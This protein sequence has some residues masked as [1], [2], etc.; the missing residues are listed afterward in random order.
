MSEK[1]TFYY[2]FNRLNFWL[3][4][5][6]VISYLLICC[7]IKYRYCC[8][9]TEYYILLALM[10]IS[11]GLW[12]YKH[13]IKQTLAII[14]DEYIKIDH[15]HPLYWQYVISAE[16]KIVRCCFR[17]FKIIVFNTKPNM[18]YK[19]NFL[20]K[21]NGDFTPFSLPLYPVVTKDEAQE[22]KELLKKKTQYIALEEDKK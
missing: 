8:Y 13:L 14:T 7:G 6:I 19:Y 18:E 15:C 16:E 21:H 11:W 9:W 17:K 20:Q 3:L 5:N 4:L 12:I 22:I 1:T 2:H 10:L